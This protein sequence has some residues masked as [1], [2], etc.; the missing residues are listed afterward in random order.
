MKS[1]GISTELEQAARTLSQRL[2][3]N[4]WFT[5]VGVTADNLIIYTS[6]PTHPELAQYCKH[7]WEGHKCIT[8]KM[9]K[10]KPA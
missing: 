7:G 1:A 9:G 2:L 10:P 5:A 8:K 3:G 4:K 6:T